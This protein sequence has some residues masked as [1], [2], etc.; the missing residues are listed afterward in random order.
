[1]AAA[2]LAT[3]T[4]VR[5]GE[6]SNRDR[7]L[8]LSRLERHDGNVRAARES[9]KLTKTTFYRYLK[10]LGIKTGDE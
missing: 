10:A 7:E 2:S 5:L 3:A 8:V 1:M 4:L 9:L 6:L